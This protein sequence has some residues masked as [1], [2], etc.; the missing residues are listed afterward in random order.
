MKPGTPSSA[1]TCAANAFV[2]WFDCSHVTVSNID[3]YQI[4]HSFCLFQL[5]IKYIYNLHYTYTPAL[6][7]PKVK[8]CIGMV[9]G[10]CFI[11][12]LAFAEM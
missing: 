4:V 10:I 9:N 8:I 3:W 5:G 2:L 7:Q 11:K 6:G 12:M 1:A